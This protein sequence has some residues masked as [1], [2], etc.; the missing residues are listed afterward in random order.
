[1]MEAVRPVG[2]LDTLKLSF[3]NKASFTGLLACNTEGKTPPIF[4]M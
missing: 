1:M 4:K 3:V 2:L